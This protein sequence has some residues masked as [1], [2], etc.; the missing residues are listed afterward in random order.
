MEM[1]KCP[2]CGKMHP[3]IIPC[4]IC[5]VLKEAPKEKEAKTSDNK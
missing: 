1:I 4:P 5:R 3:V 2:K